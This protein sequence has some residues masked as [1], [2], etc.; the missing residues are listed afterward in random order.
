MFHRFLWM[1][2][3][4]V[5]GPLLLFGAGSEWLIRTHVAPNQN[6]EAHARFL[7][8]AANPNAA[9]GD[10]HVAM[11]ITGSDDI[12][13]LGF[14]A[15]T[16]N[17]VIGKA[18]LYYSRVNPGKVILQADLQQLT[19]GRLLQSFETD[20]FL[21]AGNAWL[22]DV[23]KLS[24]PVYRTNIIGHWRN[25]LSGGE[26]KRVR[27]FQT[28][29]GSQTADTSIADWDDERVRAFANVILY[30]SSALRID[31][32]HPVLAQYEELA[33]WL[34][35]KG[36]SVCFVAYPLDHIFSGLA[37][38]LQTEADAAAL[39]S[40]MAERVGARYFNY[41]HQPFPRSQFYDPDH[42]NRMGGE[43]FTRR[44]MQD[45]FS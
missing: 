39:F 13:S 23:L 24:I 2:L 15:D 40:G 32:K 14:P 34:V 35:G 6:I 22:I 12:I 5:L 9:F 44:V 29:D 33:A 45:C 25:F 19:P 21:F 42:L 16:L 43:A 30:D 26:F 1:V 3:A 4:T 8:T 20:R 31:L 41:R 28:D 27:Q 10:S 17:H 38:T 11:G 7:R 18:R 37:Q 36:A